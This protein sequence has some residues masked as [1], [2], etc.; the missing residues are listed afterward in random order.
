MITFGAETIFDVIEEVEP[1]LRDHYHALAKNQDRVALKP[2]WD[3]YVDL[4]NA[5]AFF[6]Y[7]ARND[8]ELVGYSAFFASRHPH[9]MDLMLVSND[10]LWLA[11]SHRTGRTGVRFIRH[12][13]EQIQHRY[14]KD[15]ALTWHAKAGTALD[16][17]LPRMQ[18]GL[19]DIVY[20]KL[21]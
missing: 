21:F 5:G 6:I 15:F 3:R 8:G 1:L 13:E 20:S 4:Q 11:E 7:T 18:Y 2:D 10:V 19:Q 14:G 17:M 16:A 12:C 9:Y